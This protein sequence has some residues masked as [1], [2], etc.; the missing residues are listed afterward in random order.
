MAPLRVD[1]R[2]GGRQSR[3][4]LSG[5]LTY[6]V[7]RERRNERL[8]L[9]LLPKYRCL[10]YQFRPADFVRDLTRPLRTPA[11]NQAVDEY[12]DVTELRVAWHRIG[13]TDVSGASHDPCRD[14]IDGP[15]Y[16][17]HFHRV[18]G[19]GPRVKFRHPE[20]IGVAVRATMDG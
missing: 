13:H 16:Q 2:H 18:C 14:F 1:D 3:S 7:G 20:I 6:T 11:Q 10:I 17:I 4:P 5:R 12:A 9:A 19:I 8:Q 15:A